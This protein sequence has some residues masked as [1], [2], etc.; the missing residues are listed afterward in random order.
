MTD[1]ERLAEAIAW[2]GAETTYAPPP[3]GSEDA[4]AEAWVPDGKESRIAEA[5]LQTSAR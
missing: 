2:W 3:G 1:S 5:V 4:S